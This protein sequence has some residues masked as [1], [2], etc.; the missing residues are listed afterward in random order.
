[1][2]GSLGHAEVHLGSYEQVRVRVQ[3]ALPIAQELDDQT[4]VGLYL[5]LLGSVALAEEAYAEAWQLLEESVAI[6]REIKYREFLD[7]GLA[8]RGY[9]ARGLGQ[10]PQAQQYLCEVLQ[11]VADN[12]AFIPSMLALPAVALLLVDRGEVERAVELYGLASR[13]EFVAN[14]RWFEDVAGRHIAEVAATLPPEVVA[15]AQERGR[16]RDLDAT[17][18]ELLAELE[19]RAPRL[20]AVSR[21]HS[22]S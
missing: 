7:Q 22:I 21:C 18:A 19:E 5:F 20:C 12:R 9:A 3:I 16:A 15:A 13:Y 11:I 14:S 17:V 10:L 2:H 1:M 8:V 4:G 6:S